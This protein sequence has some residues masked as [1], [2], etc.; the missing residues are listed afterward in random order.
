MLVYGKAPL[1]A[2]VL[3]RTELFAS[4]YALRG[5]PYSETIAFETQIAKHIY[6]ALSGSLLLRQREHETVTETYS[7]KAD[8]WRG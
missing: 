7:C 3:V 4:L 1:K 5:F 6:G 8:E 2:H